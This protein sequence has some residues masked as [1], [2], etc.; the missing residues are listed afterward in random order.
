MPPFSYDNRTLGGTGFSDILICMFESFQALLPLFWLILFI[1]ILALI[2]K[3]VMDLILGKQSA[4]SFP[5]S[6]KE[7]VMTPSEQKYFRKLEQQ[8]GQTHYILCQVALDRII[9]T[10]DHKNFY[11]YWNKINKKSIDFVLIE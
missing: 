4:N 11:T 6:K 8:F 9:N 3:R 10:T 1:V 2:S 5:Y 7:S